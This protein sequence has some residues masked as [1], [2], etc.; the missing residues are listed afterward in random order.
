MD[1]Q[2]LETYRCFTTKKTMRYLNKC[3]IKYQL[4]DMIENGMSKGECK[5]I[6]QET[7]GFCPVVWKGWN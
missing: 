6:K 5:R 7:I 2:I 3:N 4:I 1:V